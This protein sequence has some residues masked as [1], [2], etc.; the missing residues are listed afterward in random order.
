[1]AIRT[2]KFAD[3]LKDD[4]VQAINISFKEQASAIFDRK[5]KEANKEIED[6]KTEIVTNAIMRVY[7]TLRV[8][9]LGRTFTIEIVKKKI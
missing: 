1:M 7:D 3:F 8:N 9:D 2:T 5:L 6:K 4:L